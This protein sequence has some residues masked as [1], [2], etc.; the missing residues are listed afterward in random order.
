MCTEIRAQ[1]EITLCTTWISLH[2]CTYSDTAYVCASPLGVRKV[3]WVFMEELQVWIHAEFRVC[4]ISNSQSSNSSKSGNFWTKWW[5]QLQKFLG[6]GT[7]PSRPLFFI[8]MW[9]CVGC[10]LFPSSSIHFLYFNVFLL[11]SQFFKRWRESLT[12]YKGLPSDIALKFFCCR[13]LIILQLHMLSS[14]MVVLMQRF[15]SSMAV[16][17]LVNGICL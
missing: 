2:I 5:P 17:C 13:H 15:D 12:K 4:M 16:C 9:P 7:L 11:Y 6:A 1:H 14:G 8:A 3:S 10:F